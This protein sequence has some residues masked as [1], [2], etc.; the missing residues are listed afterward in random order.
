MLESSCSVHDEC[1]WHHKE[2]NN[3]QFHGIKLLGAAMA[4][5]PEKTG[6]KPITQERKVAETPPPPSHCK[7]SKECRMHYN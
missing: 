4:L 6:S 1:T 5:L 3:P 7:T 2:W